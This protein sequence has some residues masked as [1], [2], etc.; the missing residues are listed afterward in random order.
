MKISKTRG[1]VQ[2]KK[3][4]YLKTLSLRSAWIKKLIQ[5]K[6]LRIPKNQGVD[7]FPDPVGHFGAPW[8]P[9]WMLQAVS[10]CPLR[11]QPG[12]YVKI[13]REGREVNM[14]STTNTVSKINQS[15]IGW[16]GGG[17]TSIQ[18]MSLNI[19]LLFFDVTPK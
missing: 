8:R 12:I 7:T 15:K 6:L 4:V 18:I 9:F 3:T 5:L 13:S 11:S 1:N 10:K 17:S 16:E 2:K 19:L 14:I